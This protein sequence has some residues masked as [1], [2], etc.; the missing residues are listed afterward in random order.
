MGIIT[1]RTE[2]QAVLFEEE[3]RGQLSDGFWENSR[4]FGHYKPWCNAEVHV[5]IDVGRNFCVDRCNYNLVSK[6]LLDV[7]GQRMINAVKLARHFGKEQVTLLDQLVDL[8][9]N[10]CGAP[11]YIGEY[12]DI[13]RSKLASVD[14][15]EV[16]RV[17]QADTY[18]MRNL[19]K[20]LR[21]M[22]VAFRNWN[23]R[24]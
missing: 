2:D 11:T 15:D 1:F 7:V 16:R 12:Y 24:K 3:I 8:D 13:I 22:K 19:R 6:E 18:T 20:D 9:G 14:F 21:E 10:F 5:G 17:V 23:W 4:P